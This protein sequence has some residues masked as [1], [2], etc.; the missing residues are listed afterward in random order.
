MKLTFDI[1]L[2]IFS[3]MFMSIMF[4]NM[5]SPILF[6]SL[7]LTQSILMCLLMWFF[8]KSSWFSYILFLIFLGGL[9]VLF[10]YMTSLAS[11]E[12][13]LPSNL[14]KKII[15]SF[16]FTIMIF[17]TTINQQP[18][19]K[20]NFYSTES[21]NSLY[22]STFMILT[23]LIMVYLLLTLIVAMKISNKFNAPIKTMTT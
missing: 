14:N 10:I 22:E 7:I 12:F 6:M 2:L 17:M 11:N 3:S 19:F 15:L 23:A 16:M 21:F 4:M 8:I 20:N 13:I 9:M 1:K 5:T 18:I